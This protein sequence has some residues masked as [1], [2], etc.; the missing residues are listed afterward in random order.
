MSLKFDMNIL[1]KKA[2]EYM[3]AREQREMAQLMA[4]TIN[5]KKCYAGYVASFTAYKQFDPTLYEC[6]SSKTLDI[7]NTSKSSIEKWSR[8][9][10]NYVVYKNCI[11]M[12][13]SMF[14]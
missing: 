14:Q 1:E 5:P 10:P 2:D 13:P 6:S 7:A 12:N 4:S 3:A 8:E 11:R 9:N